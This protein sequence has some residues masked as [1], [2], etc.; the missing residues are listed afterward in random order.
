MQHSR[1]IFSNSHKKVEPVVPGGS[2]CD[3]H[4]CI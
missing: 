4:Q 3:Q 1:D 2:R